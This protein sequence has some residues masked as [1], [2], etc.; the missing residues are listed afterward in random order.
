MGKGLGRQEVIMARKKATTRK[1]RPVAVG[2]I[3]VS[4]DEQTKGHSLEIQESTIKRYASSHG[5][6]LA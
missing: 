4:S 5:Y 6:R 1:K 3:R 2:Y